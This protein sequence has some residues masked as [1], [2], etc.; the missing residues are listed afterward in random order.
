MRKIMVMS[1]LA[2]GLSG[3][4]PTTASDPYG[5]LRRSSMASVNSMAA[6]TGLRYSDEGESVVIEA[7]LEQVREMLKDPA[8]AQF[9]NVR[10]VDHAKGKVVCGEVNAKNSYGGY[11][12]F[13]LFVAGVNGAQLYSESEYGAI[14]GAANAGLTLA[15]L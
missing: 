7:A 2:I 12:G 10:V 4:A 11:V 5:D 3:C 13:T 9:R 6:P 8:S 15:C 1:I 14:E